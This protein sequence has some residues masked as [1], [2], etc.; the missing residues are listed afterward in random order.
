MVGF[1]IDACPPREP[2]AKEK[3]EAKIRWCRQHVDP[4]SRAFDSLEELQDHTDREIER[5]AKR[6]ICPATGRSVYESWEAEREKLS[7]LPVLPEPFDI[8]VSRPVHKDCTIR[9]EDRCYAVPFA[10]VG[11]R[12]EVRGCAGKVQIVAAGRVVQEYPRNT[13]ERLL[14]DPRCYEGPATDRVEAP[15]PLGRMA[16]KLTDTA[17]M[18]VARRPI[19]L[20]AALAEVAR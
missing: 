14:V 2:N 5:W 12:V 1:H 9:F 6:A 18:P 20:Y 19:D 8:V 3:V 15:R 11:K 7:P 4:S 13:R 16:R 10:Y 17:A